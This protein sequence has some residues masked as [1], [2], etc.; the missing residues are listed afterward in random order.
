MVAVVDKLAVWSSRQIKIARKHV[1]RVDAA[2][3][4]SIAWFTIARLET[5]LAAGFGRV[6]LPTA[7]ER[8]L[9]NAA[10]EWRWQFV[11]P[12]GRICRDAR[13]GPPSRFPLHETVVQRAVAEAARRAGLTRRVTCHTFRHSRRTYS[14]RGTTS[15]RCRNCSATAA[16]RLR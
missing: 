7:L 14:R 3:V 11:F 1:P 5:D 12:A 9:P 2:I 4:I 6:V 16:C 15:G 10:T 13:Y 8:K